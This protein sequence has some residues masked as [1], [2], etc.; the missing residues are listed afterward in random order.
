[1]EANDS[2]RDTLDRYHTLVTDAGIKAKDWAVLQTALWAIRKAK[3]NYREQRLPHVLTKAAEYFSCVTDHRYVRLTLNDSGF[4]AEQADGVHVPA[5]NL[6]RGTAEQLYLCLR[7]A[8]M[9]AFH[10]YETMPMIVD[11]SFVNFDALRTK[12]SM[13]CLRK[14]RRSDKSL[15]YLP[16]DCLPQGACGNR[17]ES[18]EAAQRN[19]IELNGTCQICFISLNS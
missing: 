8:L 9:D 18:V 12:K 7:L 19:G 10:G 6:S 11:D 3:E 14:L 17:F 13:H 15:F 5:A 16:Q 2:Y 1:M 4:M